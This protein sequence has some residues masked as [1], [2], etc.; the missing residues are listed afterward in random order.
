ML[1]VLNF[2]RKYWGITKEIILALAA[3]LYFAIGFKLSPLI[4]RIDALETDR[5]IDREAF[6]SFSVATEQ[7]FKSDESNT[8]SLSTSVT[9]I[10]TDVKNIKGDTGLLIKMHLKGS[11]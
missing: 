10:K 9:E 3:I 4:G 11:E 1:R 6:K 2:V 7:R 5:E 8:Q